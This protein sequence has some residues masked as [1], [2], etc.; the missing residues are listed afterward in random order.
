MDINTCYTSVYDKIQLYALK[1]KRVFVIYNRGNLQSHNICVMFDKVF[2]NKT[3]HYENDGSDYEPFYKTLTHFEIDQKLLNDQLESKYINFYIQSF[4]KKELCYIS[5]NIEGEHPN[6]IYDIIFGDSIE[7]IKSLETFI[8][9]RCQPITRK[10]QLYVWNSQYGQYVLDSKKMFDKKI[11]DLFGIDEYYLNFKNDYE[12]Y[13]KFKELLIKIGESNGLNYMLYGPPGT[14]KSSFVR[15]IAS[16]FE[17]PIYIAKLT[18]AKDENQV[19]NMLIPIVDYDT[20]KIVLI[21]DFDRYLATPI[22]NVTMSA[23]LNAL[24]GVFPA[25]NIIRF[26]S[27]NDASIIK[28]NQALTSRMNRIIYFDLPHEKEIIAQIRNI[29][30]N[31]LDID[32]INTFVQEIISLKLSMRQLTHYFCQFLGT[33]NPAQE[34]INSKNKWLSDIKNFNEY[35]KELKKSKTETNKSSEIHGNVSS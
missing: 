13:I 30:S 23:V 28:R 24:D 27:A 1:Y 8:K 6:P 33:E 19:T 4:H 15:A 5:Q 7:L 18:M 20:F 35:E 9:L 22:G 32:L 31:N 29:F 2:P 17:I 21:E 34:M 12:R 14:G 25:F 16:E 11:S 26:F 10:S 3:C